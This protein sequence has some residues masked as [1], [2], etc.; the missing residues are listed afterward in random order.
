MINYCG[1][2]TRNSAS[3][4]GGFLTH[5]WGRISFC[6]PPPV[7]GWGPSRRPHRNTRRTR[8]WSSWKRPP[9]WWWDGLVLDQICFSGGT[10]TIWNIE[11]PYCWNHKKQGGRVPAPEYLWLYQGCFSLV[12]T[13]NAI[14]CFHTQFELCIHFLDFLH[15]T[16][17][18]TFYH[19]HSE[20]SSDNFRFRQSAERQPARHNQAGGFGLYYSDWEC[21]RLWLAEG[22][23]N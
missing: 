4:A 6:C 11:H 19:I 18:I 21:V 13:N 14:L 9:S 10:L 1:K 3:G 5:R 16:R 8:R 20:A 15:L 23:T 7:S 2:S 12:K 22:R 17:I